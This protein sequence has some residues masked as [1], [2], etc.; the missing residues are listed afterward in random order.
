MNVVF[1]HEQSDYLE[2]LPISSKQWSVSGSTLTFK[3]L[4]PL[5]NKTV[6]FST[7]YNQLIS[8]AG[9]KDR[10][11]EV[12]DM[13]CKEQKC[14]E[15]DVKKAK[16][17]VLKLKDFEYKFYGPEYMFWNPVAK[18]I[19]CRFE[20]L[21][22]L[23]NC[24]GAD[25]IVGK[26]F[27][28]KFTPVFRYVLNQKLQNV[29]SAYEAQM[30]FLPYFDNYKP[31]QSVKIAIIVV[32]VLIVLVMIGIFIINRMKKTTNEDYHEVNA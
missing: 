20:E 10:C 18:T 29:G 12:I 4:P 14:K 6:C 16:E 1:N 30:A 11:Q 26:S 27:Y 9:A 8:F 23:E 17:M 19:Q 28:N 22:A 31:S 25:I 21:P 2:T 15:D 3:N 32:A 7:V 13:I 24:P 5:E